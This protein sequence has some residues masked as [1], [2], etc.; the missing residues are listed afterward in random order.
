M[1]YRSTSAALPQKRVDTLIDSQAVHEIKQNKDIV[2]TTYKYAMPITS[3][4]TW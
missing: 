4:T 1:R 2:S 3:S